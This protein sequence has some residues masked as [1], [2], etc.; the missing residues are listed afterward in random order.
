[1]KSIKLAH[2]RLLLVAS[3]SSSSSFSRGFIQFVARYKNNR[4]WVVDWLYYDELKLR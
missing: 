4:C 1:M 2:L 3:S